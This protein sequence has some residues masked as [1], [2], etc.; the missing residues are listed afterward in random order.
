MANLLDYLNANAGAN[1]VPVQGVQAPNASPS[2]LQALIS[3]INNQSPA[4]YD[5][6]PSA[7]AYAD[8][9]PGEAPT[10]D[11]NATS[12]PVGEVDIQATKP[13]PAPMDYDNSASVQ[14]LQKVN[15]ANNASPGHQQ[16]LYG[17]IPKGSGTLSRVLGVLGDA[18]LVGGNK[19]PAYLQMLQ[20]QQ[21]ADALAGY[22][23]NNPE[24]GI[25][26]LVATA[27][28]DSLQEG[29]TLRQAAATQALAKQAQINAQTY[30]DSQTNDR[31]A[32]IFT[33][34]T[35]GATGAVQGITDPLKYAQMY[36]LLDARAKLVDQR[37]SAATAYGIPTPE[38]WTPGSI[39]GLGM[40][41]NQQQVSADKG[42]QR[43][44]SQT[45]AQIGAGARVTAAQIYASAH[46][47][48][49]NM[50]TELNEIGQ[51][52]DEGTATPSE[53]AIFKHYASPPRSSGYGGGGLAIQ[54][55]GGGH[56]Q[57]APQQQQQGGSIPITMAGPNNPVANGG[58]PI[59]PAQSHTLPKGIH[60]LGGDGKWRIS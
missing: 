41:S 6:T 42:S 24:P 49:P 45:N 14:A 55:Q 10:A 7:Q 21:Q 60:Y 46:P 2:P 43:Q 57:P 35:P 37:A 13:K 12:T 58:H 48:Q 59:T 39:S 25:Q 31:N 17:A 29:T 22:D 26:R 38:T 11:P 47:Q 32:S 53:Q 51:K 18:F 16:S 3:Q 54:P 8:S 19:Q 28:P 52:M 27:T 9:S 5:A 23:P 4:G 44:Q 36:S 20:R 1:S 40:T 30:R 15:A 34:Q 56:P 33:R 50:P